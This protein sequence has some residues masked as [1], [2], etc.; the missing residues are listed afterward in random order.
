MPKDQ[1][2]GTA[3]A[4]PQRDGLSDMRVAVFMRLLPGSSMVKMAFANNH[5]KRVPT[6]DGGEVA[7]LVKELT[8]TVVASGTCSTLWMRWKGRNISPASI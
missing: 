4:S 5:S 1:L 6:I 7:K 3:P 2:N 8:I